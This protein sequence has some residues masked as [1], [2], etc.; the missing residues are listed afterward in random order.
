[1]IHWLL[2]LAIP[3]QQHRFIRTNTTGLYRSSNITKSTFSSLY[4]NGFLLIRLFRFFPLL[5]LY[6]IT[7]TFLYLSIVSTQQSLPT[8][9]LFSKFSFQFIHQFNDAFISISFST[10]RESHFLFI[11][12]F[13]SVFIYFLISLHCISFDFRMRKFDFD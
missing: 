5:H 6:A 11:C 13:S 7:L 1:M 8:I 2:Q 4:Q 9:W 12:S 3:D 10:N